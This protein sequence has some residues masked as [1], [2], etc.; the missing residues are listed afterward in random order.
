MDNASYLDVPQT[1]AGM[2]PPA[3]Q[4]QVA[5]SRLGAARSTLRTRPETQTLP[6]ERACTDLLLN[7]LEPAVTTGYD[8]TSRA[9][10]NA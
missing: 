6:S 9:K 1:T 8:A 7:E 10:V 2:H 3:R 5:K 4:Q